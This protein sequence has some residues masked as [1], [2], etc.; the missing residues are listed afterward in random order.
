MVFKKF[1]ELPFVWHHALLTDR[2]KHLLNFLH[3]ILGGV[4][5]LQEPVALACIGLIEASTCFALLLLDFKLTQSLQ[6][7]FI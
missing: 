6:D 3:A 2:I 4:F 7:D 1:M 5:H